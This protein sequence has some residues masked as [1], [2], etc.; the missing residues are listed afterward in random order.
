MTPTPALNTGLDDFLDW[1]AREPGGAPPARPA[2]AVLT[3]LALH[4]ADRRAGVPE[5]TPRLVARI[6][7]EDLP[8]LLGASPEEA[9]AVP[10]VLRSLADCV[11]QSGRLNAKRHAR[12]LAAV[13]EA[14]PEFVEAV[15]DPARLTWHRWYAARLRADG[16]DAGDRAA[17]RAWLDTHAR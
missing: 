15:D 17:V 2:D 16:T 7:R 1:A 11:R 3:L 13:D 12:L 9:A 5:P 8:G 6:L 4:G 10:A 14:A